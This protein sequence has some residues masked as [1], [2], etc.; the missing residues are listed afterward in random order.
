MHSLQIFVV[1]LFVLRF[2]GIQGVRITCVQI[3]N[4][5]LQMYGSIDYRCTGTGYVSTDQGL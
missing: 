3:M 1:L 4:V 2:F 5:Q